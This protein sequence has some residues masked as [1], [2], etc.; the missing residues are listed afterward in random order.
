MAV[1]KGFYGLFGVRDLQIPRKQS[2]EKYVTVEDRVITP[3]MK[4][5]AD[6]KSAEA[7]REI[8]RLFKG[9][10]AAQPWT[11][12][13]QQKSK[14]HII[15]DKARDDN[16]RKRVVNKTHANQGKKSKYRRNKQLP[17]MIQAVRDQAKLLK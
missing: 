2:T 15:R 6:W 8:H 13:A 16:R 4:D 12:M 11:S 5:S 1:P 7:S 10:S 3:Q 9:G 17:A 14:K